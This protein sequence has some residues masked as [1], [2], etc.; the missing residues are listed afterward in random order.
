MFRTPGCLDPDIRVRSNRRGPGSRQSK[1]LEQR[2]RGDTTFL[3]VPRIYTL[4]PLVVQGPFTS[5]RLDG[6]F[7]SRVPLRLT[8][9][10]M[11][12]P[13]SRSGPLVPNVQGPVVQPEP[14]AFLTTRR[15]EYV[16][17]GI[18]VE[19]LSFASRPY[20]RSCSPSGSLPTDVRTLPVTLPLSP[21]RSKDDDIPLR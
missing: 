2:Y 5:L 4:R 3:H 14:R 1:D 15:S 17:S 10:L 11:R 20:P 9:R 12:F 7:S 6:S 16:H 21:R 19:R 18:P 8:K 13:P